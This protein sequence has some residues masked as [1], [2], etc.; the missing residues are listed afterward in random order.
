M[1]IPQASKLIRRLNTINL[2]KLTDF[3]L[4]KNRQYTQLESGKLN[5][6]YIEVNLGDMQLFIESLNVG[7]RIEAAPA[8][9]Y[10]PFAYIYPRISEHRFCGQ[11]HNN[12]S[13][14][15]ASGGL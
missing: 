3:Q 6:Q 2:K 15:Q 7:A 10:L 1:H 12:N 11:E 4:N 14:I 13:L 9:H 8:K 5:A